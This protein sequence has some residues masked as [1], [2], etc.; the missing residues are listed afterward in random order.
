M[1]DGD[2]KQAVMNAALP[3]EDQS[4]NAIAARMNRI[5]P[6]PK[7]KTVV[8]VTCPGGGIHAAAWSTFILED[9]QLLAD[10]SFLTQFQRRCENPT[11]R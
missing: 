10:G 3:L 8:L 6:S 4:W 5:S 7:K 11:F 2:R 9:L 1:L